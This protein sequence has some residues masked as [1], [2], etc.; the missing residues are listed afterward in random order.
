MADSGYETRIRNVQQAEY[1]VLNYI[2]NDERIQDV[3][4]H[5]LSTCCPQ[6]HTRAGKVAIARSNKAMANLSD[7]LSRMKHKRAKFLPPAHIDYKGD[8]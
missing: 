6:Q 2:L 1:E 3:L 8:A 7:I 4:K 5:R